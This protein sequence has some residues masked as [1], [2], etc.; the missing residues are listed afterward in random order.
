MRVALMP[1]AFWPAV[2]GVEELTARL[3]KALQQGGDLVEIWAPLDLSLDIPAHETY[4][5]LTVRRFP[6]PRLQ[7]N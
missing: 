1:S 2:G 3:A 7:R 6:V 5:E 4:Q